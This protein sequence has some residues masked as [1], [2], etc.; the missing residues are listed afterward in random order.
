MIVSYED[1]QRI[2]CDPETATANQQQ[3][4]ALKF[5][6]KSWVADGAIP[7]RDVGDLLTGI[8]EDCGA[9]IE[10]AAGRFLPRPEAKDVRRDLVRR[11]GN[12]VIARDA[13]VK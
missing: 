3:D 2:G 13:K 4:A 9:A 5:N 12:R 8:D 7:S 6:G 11:I 10:R 1:W